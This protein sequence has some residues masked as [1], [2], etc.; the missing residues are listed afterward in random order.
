G[1]GSARGPVRAAIERAYAAHTAARPD[2]PPL[3]TAVLGPDAGLVG[4]ASLV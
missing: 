2:A 3:L 4:A 1:L